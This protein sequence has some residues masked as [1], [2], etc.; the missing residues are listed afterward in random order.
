MAIEDKSE[1]EKISVLKGLGEE[2]IYLLIRREIIYILN[3]L[4]FQILC[5]LVLSV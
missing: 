1:K 4:I 3:F 5:L 2:V